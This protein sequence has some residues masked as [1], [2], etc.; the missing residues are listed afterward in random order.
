MSDSTTSVSPGE[1]SPTLNARSIWSRMPIWAWSLGSVCL[2]LLAAAAAFLAPILKEQWAVGR[3]KATPGVSVTSDMGDKG[4]SPLKRLSAPARFVADQL[5][6]WFGNGV[7]PAAFHSV[8]LENA[9]PGTLRF[10]AALRRVRFLEIESDDVTDEELAA[11]P[12]FDDLETLSLKTRRVS[13]AGILSLKGFSVRQ[14][15]LNGAGFGNEHLAAACRAFPAME[16]LLL[17][18]ASIDDR[19][20]EALRGH[21]GIEYVDICSTPI[22]D[23]GLEPLTKVPCLATLSFQDIPLSDSAIAV[24]ARM[25]S[26]TRLEVEQTRMTRS[27]LGRLPP[28]IKWYHY[29]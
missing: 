25:T 12:R 28:R 24:F 10:V 29:E 13:P 1:P 21:P 23:T 14:F 7:W 19:G 20:L 22:T 9:P 16:N 11:L 4:T 17:R 27:G 15:H 26:L 6:D 2:L 3:L 5:A 18:E 8:E